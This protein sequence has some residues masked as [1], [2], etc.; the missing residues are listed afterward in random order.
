MSRPTG[1]DQKK[2]KEVAVITLGLVMLPSLSF[3]SVSHGPVPFPIQ[4]SLLGWHICSQCCCLLEAFAPTLSK[5]SLN[6]TSPTHETRGGALD[7]RLGSA[8]L[9][10]HPP[11]DALSSVVRL[12]RLIANLVPCPFLSLLTFV[13]RKPFF[14]LQ[15]PRLQTQLPL[16]SHRHRPLIEFVCPVRNPRRRAAL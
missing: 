2:K 15:D 6:H 13:P 1:N 14:S 3:F 12:Q 9:F 7:Q 10:L 5:G 4:S 16:A 11:D 8:R